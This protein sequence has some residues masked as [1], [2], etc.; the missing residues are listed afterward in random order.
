MKSLLLSQKT[1]EIPQ[2]NQEE[3]KE[4]DANNKENQGSAEKNNELQEKKSK[5]QLS[6]LADESSDGL[7]QASKYEAMKGRV[8]RLT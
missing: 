8:I 3:Q 7:D 2:Q 5:K 6:L 1:D 4:D